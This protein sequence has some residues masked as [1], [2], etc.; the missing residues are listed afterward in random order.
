MATRCSHASGERIPRTFCHRRHALARVSCA[1]S[2]PRALSPQY[3]VR[4]PINFGCSR[5]QKE[6]SSASGPSRD[7]TIIE[8][9]LVTP[10]GFQASGYFFRTRA[11]L[12]GGTA[13]KA[14]DQRRLPTE[15]GGAT[16]SRRD[17]HRGDRQ[18]IHRRV[19]DSA[20]TDAGQVS[21]VVARSFRSHQ[22]DQPN[23]QKVRW[24]NILR[25]GRARKLRLPVT[26]CCTRI[27]TFFDGQATTKLLLHRLPLRV[28]RAM[29]GSRFTGNRP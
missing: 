21:P 25:G 28:T 24:L 12:T 16:H 8:G 11:P 13:A 7:G 23:D 14:G 6:I 26:S 2:S 15:S 27:M 29:M 18:E 10:T 5:S 3:R 1:T 19:L 4:T 20:L 17:C 9:T 22:L